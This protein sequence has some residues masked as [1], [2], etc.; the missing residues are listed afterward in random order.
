MMVLGGDGSNTVTSRWAAWRRARILLKSVIRGA[1]FHFFVEYRSGVL[2]EV[3]KAYPSSSYSTAPWQYAQA[4]AP[5]GFWPT[6]ALSPG[7]AWSSS[8]TISANKSRMW[9]A[10]VDAPDFSAIGSGH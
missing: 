6:A 7:R 1:P 10:Q 5:P 9:R 8:G 2:P 3:A 4:I